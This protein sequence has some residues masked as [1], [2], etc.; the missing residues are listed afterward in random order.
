MIYIICKLTL[1]KIPLSYTVF[2][3]VTANTYKIDEVTYDVVSVQ[4]FAKYKAHRHVYK[5]IVIS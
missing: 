5:T 3:M 1:N 4:L 2:R